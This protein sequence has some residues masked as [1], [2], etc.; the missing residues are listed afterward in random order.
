MPVC[1]CRVCARQKNR[2]S[3]DF[4]LSFLFHLSLSFS[5][6]F[7]FSPT[8]ALRLLR[9]LQTEWV[10]SFS[11]HVPCLNHEGSCHPAAQRAACYSAYTLTLPEYFLAP[12]APLGS[13]PRTCLVLGAA[14]PRLPDRSRLWV[15]GGRVSN[16][17]AV[18]SCGFLLLRPMGCSFKPQ[19]S[20]GARVASQREVTLSLS[21]SGCSPLV[22]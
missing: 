11:P 5:S 4:S 3:S 19:G 17:M 21:P 18:R 16:G 2:L 9:R 13:A 10:P 8:L 12:F 6:R 15:G 20:H 22:V 1:R 14:C 7:F